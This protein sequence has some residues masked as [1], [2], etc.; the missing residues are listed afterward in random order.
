MKVGEEA[1]DFSLPDQNDEEVSLN[2]FEDRKVLLSF[3]PLAWTSVCKKQMLSLEDSYERFKDLNTIPLGISADPVPTKK[4]W[5]KEIGLEKLRIP[6]DFWPH[7]EVAKKYGIFREDDGFSERA[8]IL[9]DEN[10]KIEFSKVY[11][12]TE[13]PDF[14]EVIGGIQSK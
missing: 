9:V 11:E 13:V 10:R 5:A 1:K 3:H 2:Q 12:I 4:A 8:N 6:S 7:G 14:E